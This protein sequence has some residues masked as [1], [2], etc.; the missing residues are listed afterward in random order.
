MPDTLTQP[1]DLRV[2][3]RCVAIITDVAF[4]GEGVARA[5]DFVIFIPFVLSGET[6]E[7]EI[8]EVKKRFARAKLVQVLVASPHRVSPPCWY[9]GDCGGCQYQ[10]I[11]YAAQLQIKHK[12]IVDLFQRLGGVP[13]HVIEPVIP[14]PRP[15]GY[16]NKIMV[17]SQWDKIKQGLNIGFL[18]AD[19]RL[20]VDVEECHIAE[21]ALN[22][23]LQR[24]RAHPPPRGG[25]KVVLRVVPDEWEI[26]P[27]SFFQSNF[28][29]LAKLSETVRACLRHSSDRF[30]IDAYCGV[31][32]FGIELADIVEKFVGVEI[33][34]RAIV[35]ARNNAARRGITNGEYRMGLVEELLPQFLDR[36]DRRQTTVILD[37]P[38]AGCQPAI[39]QLLREAK[40]C[41]VIYVSCKPDTLA[42]DL[43][44]LCA[45]GVFEVR[46][47]VPL[48]MFPQ[49]QHVECVTDLRLRSREAEAGGASPGGELE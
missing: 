43:N 49:T 33:D 45:D 44:M 39:L 26:P 12:Q 14:S 5:N 18:R 31:G 35:A 21:P 41:Q 15:Y 29:L 8:T 36:F 40:P 3:S 42:R 7:A 17:R 20:V 38:R 19:N 24:V 11:D 34:R 27:D 30:L 46:R 2:G 4:G 10:H 32:F 23:Q 47:V 37:P 48:D 22:Q 28:F 13:A 1:V 25:F 16:R 6:V 9:F